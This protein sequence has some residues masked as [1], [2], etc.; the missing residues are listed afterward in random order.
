MNLWERI[1]GVKWKSKYFC[2]SFFC[3]E[4]FT[5]VWS[6]LSLLRY[7]KGNQSIKSS[8][9]LFIF[10]TRSF[11]SL[12][13]KIFIANIFLQKATIAAFHV[14]I[15]EK[16]DELRQIQYQH[17]AMFSSARNYNSCSSR[18]NRKLFASDI[19]NAC[20]SCGWIGNLF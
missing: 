20:D 5:Q 3:N 16:C 19:M 13:M 17:S 7:V 14:R 9:S 10:S 15:S 4:I 12:R 8:R 18:F 6:S 2:I 11:S 1:D